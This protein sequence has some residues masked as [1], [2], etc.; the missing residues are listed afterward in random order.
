MDSHKVAFVY[1]H[2]SAKSLIAAEYFSRIAIARNLR[3]R[4]ITSGPKPDMRC[5]KMSSLV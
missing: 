2:G 4:A 5:Q 3:L 1:S